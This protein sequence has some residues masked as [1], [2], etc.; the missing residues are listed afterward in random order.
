MPT[1][2]VKWYEPSKWFG[3][4]VTDEGQEVYLNASALPAGVTELRAG[5]RMDGPDR[6]TQSSLSAA[7]RI[8]RR[9]AD[10]GLSR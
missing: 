6:R 7:A 8:S 4:L 5:T 3:F 9:G 2:K 10:I 1:G